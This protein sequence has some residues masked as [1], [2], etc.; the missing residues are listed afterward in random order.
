MNSNKKSQ[1]RSKAIKQSSVWSRK[2][3]ANKAKLNVK[4]KTQLSAAKSK[5]LLGNG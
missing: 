2:G 3:T 4:T 1:A 5:K